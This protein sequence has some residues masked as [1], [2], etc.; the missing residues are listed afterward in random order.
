MVY[1][2]RFSLQIAV[3]FIILTYLVP[4]LFK[5]YIQNVLKLKKLFRRP[6][7]KHTARENESISKWKI[8]KSRVCARHNKKR[9]YIS[10][11]ILTVL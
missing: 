1:N 8:T 7:V 6:K 10:K 4:V 9:N 3:C 11:V 2:L 5:F